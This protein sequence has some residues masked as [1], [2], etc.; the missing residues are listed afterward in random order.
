MGY[1]T[2]ELRSLHGKAMANARWSG[3][4]GRE[5]VR[6]GQRGLADKFL[7]EARERFPNDIEAAVQRKADQTLKAHMQR[8]AIRSQVARQA[9]AK[10]RAGGKSARHSGTAPH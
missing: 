8:L 9:K 1:E 10:E 6:K 7:R 5:Q 3:E 2:P 4:D